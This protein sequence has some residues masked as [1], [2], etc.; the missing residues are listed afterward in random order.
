MIQQAA[1]RGAFIDQSQSINIHIADPSFGEMSS[2]H[3]FGWKQGLKTGMYSLRSK[4]DA[5][6]VQANVDKPKIANKPDACNR[7]SNQQNLGTIKCSNLYTGI[8]EYTAPDEVAI[9]NLAAIAVNAFVDKEAKKF[10]FDHLK[11]VAKVVTKHLNKIIERIYYPGIEAKNSSL[12][13][14][15]VSIG[16][17]GLADAYIL[18]KMPF[19]SEEARELNKQIFETI[20]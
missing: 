6:A 16:I 10:D 17:Q 2:M 15:P 5:Q 11:K 20:Y 3:L 18:M 13:H 8:M 1:D 4:P 9:G 12:L 19:E 14:R 7:K